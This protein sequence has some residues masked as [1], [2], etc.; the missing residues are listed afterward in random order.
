MKNMKS[1]HESVQKADVESSDRYSALRK[2]KRGRDKEELS[3][4]H[5]VISAQPLGNELLSAHLM[6]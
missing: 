3:P 2:N 6:L 5:A 1:V 4:W